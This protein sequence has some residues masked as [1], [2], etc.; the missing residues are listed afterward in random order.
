MNNVNRFNFKILCFVLVVAIL[1]A[2][3]CG[4]G[5]VDVQETGY[6][7]RSDGY[8]A[9]DFENGTFYG[10]NGL[11]T[12]H[13][14][15][16]GQGDSEFIELPNGECMLI[17]AGESGSGTYIADYISDLGYDT[18]DY[19]V[20]TH[21]HSDHIG[22]MTTIIETFDIENI[23]MPKVSTNTVTYQELLEV[24]SDKEYKIKTAEAG[25]YVV[26][27][28]ELCIKLIAPVRDYAD[29]NNAS[30]VIKIE[31]KEIGLL[32]MGDAEILAENDIYLDVDCDVIKVGHHGSDT[33][34]GNGFIERTHARYAVISVGEGNSYGHPDNEVIKRWEASGA[35]IYRTDKLGTITVT[36]DG[37]GIEIKT[38]EDV[39]VDFKWVLNTNSKRIHTK[40]CEYGVKISKVNRKSSKKSIA[41]LKR[42]GYSPC[43]IC[44]PQD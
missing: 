41:E 2:M 42:E 3:T 26:D 39:T 16:V 21:P 38:E 35:K 1:T 13:Y 14:I 40:D 20:A 22:G 23:F 43:S 27:D 24:I 9:S 28:G 15:D 11:L 36:T 10:Q 44:K 7:V 25:V 4:C 37:Y 32:F 8:T 17:D 34:S 18:I 31:Y 29:L 19:L 5:V 30:A 6:P 12:A 33:S